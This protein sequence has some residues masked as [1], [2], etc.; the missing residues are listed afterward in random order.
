MKQYVFRCKNVSKVCNSEQILSNVSMEIEKGYIYGL[1]GKNGVGKTSIIRV[2]CGLLVNDTGS[3]ELF[4][5]NENFQKERQRI[6]SL[7]DSPNLYE[8]MTARENMNLARI[9][10]GIP[11][12]KCID[13][14]LRL[15]G[16]N[17][18]GRKKVKDFSLGM[19]QKLAIALAL[20][21]SPEFLIL[22]EP[23]NG[24][25]VI[26]IK[27][28][29]D[30]IID[31]NKKKGTTILISSHILSELSFVANK[32][33]FMDKGTIINEVD[34]QEL[35]DICK[36]YIHIKVRD[37]ERAAIILERD[38]N[39]KNYKITSQ[40]SI[41]IYDD[42]DTEKIIYVLS[43]NN[44]GIKECMHVNESIEDYLSNLIGEVS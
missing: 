25:D 39:I 32:Y 38:L 41:R 21:N 37:V 22:D 15:V 34:S 3:I 1:V 28:I 2:I 26:S 27:Q 44:I 35:N 24:L 30:L 7:I 9:Q 40:E 13:E 43:K 6:S 33:I 16:L 10:R 5:N 19:K 8:N 17:N 31:I 14:N 23:I 11:G 12:E 29:R 42:L 20:M 18:V 36:K 4:G